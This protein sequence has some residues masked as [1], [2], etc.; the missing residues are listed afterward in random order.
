MTLALAST[1]YPRGELRRLER[2]L[3]QLEQVYL[4]MAVMV[5]PDVNPEISQAL[6]EITEKT[7][8]RLLHSITSEW[9]WGRYLAVKATLDFPVTHIHYVDLDR[10]LRWIETHPEEWKRTALVVQ[11]HDCLVIGRTPGAYQSHPQALVQTEKISNMVVSYLLGRQMDISA[12]SKG[13]SRSAVETLMAHCQPGHAL[14]TDAEW[15]LKLQQ[16][17]FKIEYIEVEGL[18][19]EIPDQGRP[20]AADALRQRQMALQYDADPKNWQRRVEVALE[21]VQ[22]GLE[23]LL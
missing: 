1:W 4:A 8:G 21:I 19:W 16:A 9:S 13:F 12:G 5:P 20:E 10:L 15:P 2:V 22:S 18:D 7:R 6:D 23:A 3:P 17:G 14:G 11:E